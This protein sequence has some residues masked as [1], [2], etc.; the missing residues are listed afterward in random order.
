MSNK[1]VK[2][3]DYLFLSAM[4][5]ARE[6]KMLTREKMERMLD[7]P[8]FDEAAKLM[9]DSGYAD[10]SG[11]DASQID[12]ALNQHRS[13]IFN[14]LAGILPEPE[15]VDAFRMKYDYHNAK[16]LIKA[17]GRRCGR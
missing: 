1:N 11:M 17:E 14:E 4:I 12:D 9:A 3:T 2:D 16:V 13:A 5:R 7:A 8:G 10:M 15:L 6:T